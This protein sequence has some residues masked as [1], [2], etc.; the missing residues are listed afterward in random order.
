MVSEK[1]TSPSDANGQENG[2]ILFR[3]DTPEAASDEF[4][5]IVEAAVDLARSEKVTAFEAADWICNQHK[6][7]DFTAVLEAVRSRLLAECDN[8]C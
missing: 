1:L 6:F 5:Q 7:E 8:E 4:D 3:R 2:F